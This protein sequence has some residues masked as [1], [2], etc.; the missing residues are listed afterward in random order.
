VQTKG[1]HSEGAADARSKIIPGKYMIVVV[2]FGFGKLYIFIG[3]LPSWTYQ[4]PF[5]H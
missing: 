1:D 2:A 4:Y 5:H 3:L